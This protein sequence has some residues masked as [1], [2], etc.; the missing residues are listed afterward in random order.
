MTVSGQ[1]CQLESDK[2]INWLSVLVLECFDRSDIGANFISEKYFKTKAL[3]SLGYL[4]KCTNPSKCA[5][6]GL[7]KTLLNC[8]LKN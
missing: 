5:S 2:T 8:A 7:M 6:S 4:N 3:F 1:S